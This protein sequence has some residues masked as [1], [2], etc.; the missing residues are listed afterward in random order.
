MKQGDA[1]EVAA[2]GIDITT[3]ITRTSIGFAN[4]RGHLVLGMEQSWASK[5]RT[6]GVWI[7]TVG[8]NAGLALALQRGH[9]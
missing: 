1:L 2:L 7:A 5:K 6:D 3:V 9:L 4:Q 8:Q